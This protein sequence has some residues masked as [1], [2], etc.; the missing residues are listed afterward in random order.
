MHTW[1][2]VFLCGYLAWLLGICLPVKQF[3]RVYWVCFVLRDEFISFPSPVFDISL[4]LLIPHPFPGMA[5]AWGGVPRFTAPPQLTPQQHYIALIT[6]AAA[7]AAANVSHGGI[8]GGSST[9]SSVSSAAAEAAA[10]A[11]APSL[12][13]APQGDGGFVPNPRYAAINAGRLPSVAPPLPAMS[14]AAAAAGGGEG[15]AG[16]VLRRFWGTG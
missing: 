15:A 12:E 3:A 1:L 7:A 9:V 11:A 13:G 4:S 10:A 16:V 8:D 14:A 5:A 6:D 2:C